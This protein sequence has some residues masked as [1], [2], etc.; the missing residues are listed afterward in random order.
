MTDQIADNSAVQTT[1][2]APQ[3]STTEGVSQQAE[4]AQVTAQPAEQTPAQEGSAAAGQEKEPASLAE[5]ITQ[6]QTR[7]EAQAAQQQQTEEPAQGAAEPEPGTV[8]A[9]EP[10]AETEP[11]S[12]ILG[13]FKTQADLENAYREAERKIHETGQALSLREQELL[14]LRGQAPQQGGEPQP[15]QQQQVKESLDQMTFEQQ[16]EWLEKFYDMPVD[17]I[18]EI[19]QPQ[20]RQSVEPIAKRIQQREQQEIWG[21][22]ISAVRQSHEDFNNLVPEIEKAMSDPSNAY[23]AGAPN[24]FEA[25][26]NLVKS[27]QVLSQANQPQ[28][29]QQVNP[30]SLLKDP[31]FRRK[32]L[33]DQNIRNEILKNYAQGVKQGKP[34]VVIGSQ[35]GG[36]P[37]AAPTEPITS[38]REATKH[39]KNFF[40]RMMGG[41]S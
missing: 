13:K 38:T 1:E 17:A 35:P 39:A 33:E 18:M 16:Q 19:L 24:P 21:R 32:I 26:Y 6:F 3:S 41:S 11:Q 40:S 7:Q 14:A 30:D 4:G 2:P 36:Q 27:R 29:Q 22:Q 15:E 28:Q 23:L 37:P 9:Q 20:L 8:P 5:W 10:P 12:L 34:P 25:A 31:A